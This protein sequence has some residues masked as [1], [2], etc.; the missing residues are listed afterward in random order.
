MGDTIACAEE[1]REDPL[2]TPG[3]A[4][5]TLA[6]VFGVNTSPLG[7]KE[8]THMTGAHDSVVV[9]FIALLFCRLGRS[10]LTLLLAAVMVV[11]KACDVGKQQ[12]ATHLSALLLNVIPMW[13]SGTQHGVVTVRRR[14]AGQPRK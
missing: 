6:M 10:W 12:G 2:P 13:C 14:N 11:A 1:G 8:G 9:V 3:V 7:G 5:P 4:P